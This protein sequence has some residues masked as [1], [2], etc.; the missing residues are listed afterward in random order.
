M[1]RKDNKENELGI[2]CKTR[3]KEHVQ[4]KKDGV[5]CEEI[6]SKLNEL[7]GPKKAVVI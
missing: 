3:T 2:S 5:C 6:E 1:Y 7:T 4:K